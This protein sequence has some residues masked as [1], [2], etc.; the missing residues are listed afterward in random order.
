MKIR[1]AF[2]F[3]LVLTLAAGVSLV[4]GA[5]K[6]QRNLPLSE[7]T[8][9]GEATTSMSDCM[10]FSASHVSKGRTADRATFSRQFGNSISEKGNVWNYNYDEYTS[11][12]L[13]CTKPACSCRCLPKVQY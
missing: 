4:A 11:I 3:G 2:A 5:H 12:V 6:Y 8:Q 9:A 10:T 7:A 1:K 13:D